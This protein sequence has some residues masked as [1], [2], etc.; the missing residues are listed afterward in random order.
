MKA[1]FENHND[2]NSFISVE[3]I[4]ISLYIYN[5][6][7]AAYRLDILH[8]VNMQCK[9]QVRLTADSQNN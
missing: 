4:I 7:I 8:I 5:H 1:D 9:H 2:H 6:Y 3:L